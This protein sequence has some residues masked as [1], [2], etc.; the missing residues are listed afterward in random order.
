MGRKVVVRGFFFFK[1]TRCFNPQILELGND[2]E[3]VWRKN[4]K[5]KS[6]SIKNFEQK[7]LIL[8]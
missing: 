4:Y 7:I 3:N 2:F 5:Y 6:K 8:I 1:K